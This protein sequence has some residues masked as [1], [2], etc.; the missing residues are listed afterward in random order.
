M[1]EGR[2]KCKLRSPNTRRRRRRSNAET[3]AATRR[4]GGSRVVIGIWVSRQSSVSV[5]KRGAAT[6]GGMGLW[7]EGDV[8]GQGRYSSG[9]KLIKASVLKIGPDR[10][11]RPKK[12]KTDPSF[13]PLHGH[14]TLGSL[15]GPFILESVAD[16]ELHTQGP[17]VAQYNGSTV[18]SLS[19]HVSSFG[20]ASNVLRMYGANV[21]LR[22]RIRHLSKLKGIVNNFN[23][24]LMDDVEDEAMEYGDGGLGG[25]KSVTNQQMKARLEE[26]KTRRA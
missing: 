14:Q 11:V 26:F 3:T 19:P 23:F 21:V 7:K 25:S 8:M 1:A 22:Q 15:H 4:N 12:S 24:K 13:G 17:N 6:M 20:G 5:I 2:D 16:K 18:V 9:I 10:P